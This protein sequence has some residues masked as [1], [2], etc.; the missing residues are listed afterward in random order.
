MQVG[1]NTVLT[2]R[3]GNFSRPVLQIID[4]SMPETRR[5]G[6][7]HVAPV[8]TKRRTVRLNELTLPQVPET[9]SRLSCKDCSS[10]SIAYVW[11]SQHP[12]S[13]I[14]QTLVDGDATEEVNLFDE[15]VVELEKGYNIPAVGGSVL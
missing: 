5:L 12:S 6:K 15:S 7:L 13:D 3:S 2:Q 11:S 10:M 9:I 14:E 8:L 4:R 1:C